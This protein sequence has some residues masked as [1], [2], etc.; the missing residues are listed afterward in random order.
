MNAEALEERD[1]REIARS[2]IREN[3]ERRRKW[4]LDSHE[5]S[6][7][8]IAILSIVMLAALAGPFLAGQIYTADD[9][10][11]FHLPLRAFYADCLARGEPFDWS[12][13]LFCGFYLTGEGQIGGYHPLHLLLYRFLPLPVAFDLE[14]LLS[15]PFMLIGMYFLLRRWGICRGAALFGGLTFTFSGFSLLHFVHVNGV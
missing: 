11:A 7:A 9:L 14:C 10:G 8:W 1:L 3:S 2:G 5:F 12:P 6:Y 15:Y 13:Q 4:Q